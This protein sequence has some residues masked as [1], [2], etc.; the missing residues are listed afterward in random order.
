MQH[1]VGHLVDNVA[2]GRGTERRPRGL[3]SLAQ[4]DLHEVS[5][6]WR[7]RAELNVV[8]VGGGGERDDQRGAGDG[9]LDG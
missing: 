5:A 2:V 9:V 7:P 6:H 1:H 4:H 3:Q 8:R